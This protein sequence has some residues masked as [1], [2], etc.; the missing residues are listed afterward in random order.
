MQ[1][2]P[3]LFVT[4]HDAWHC[5]GNPDAAGRINFS[6]GDDP[7]PICYQ[8]VNDLDTGK[9]YLLS[10]EHSLDPAYGGSISNI[11][12]SEVYEGDG[13]D[14]T[15]VTGVTSFYV[16]FRGHGPAQ[17]WIRPTLREVLAS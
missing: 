11:A 16:N 15:E 14:T 7:F 8:T 1:C 13:L 6:D 17:G 2:G 3:N 5:E 4:S 12:G 10:V 9:T